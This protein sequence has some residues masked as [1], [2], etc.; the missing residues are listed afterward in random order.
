VAGTALGTPAYMSPE[1]ARGDT[2][3][4]DARSDVFSLRAIL[5]EVL[6]R[7]RP[8]EGATAEHVME[9]V[10]WTPRRGRRLCAT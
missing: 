2:R 10:A 9:N 4:L 1:Q 3:E 5:Y 6:T 7:R 8:F